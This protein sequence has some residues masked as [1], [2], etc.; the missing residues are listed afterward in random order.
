MKKENKLEWEQICRKC[1]KP[2]ILKMNSGAISNCCNA[3]VD[4]KCVE[5]KPKGKWKPK[6]L[7]S[8]WTINYSGKVINFIFRRENESAYDFGNIFRTE[9]EALE[10]RDKI[11]ELLNKL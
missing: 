4:L 8:Y 11:K 6:L 5:E 9:K 3:P 7:E 10:A 1:G 2:C